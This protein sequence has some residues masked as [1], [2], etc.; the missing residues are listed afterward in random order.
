[1]KT[2]KKVELWD[3]FSAEVREHIISTEMGPYV[4]KK[5]EVMTF[6]EDFMGDAV[7]HA[8]FK[9]IIK[10]T[11]RY[12]NGDLCVSSDLHKAAHYMCRLWATGR[13]ENDQ[14]K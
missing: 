6:L 11:C 1:M 8:W 2:V 12:Y 14:R 7:E 4:G 9:D 3:E 13:F 5:T 10:Y